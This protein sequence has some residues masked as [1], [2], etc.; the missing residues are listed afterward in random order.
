MPG[1]E[2]LPSICWFQSDKALKGSLTIVSSAT[3]TMYLLSVS[4][5]QV[6]GLFQG[7]PGTVSWCD[8]KLIKMTDATYSIS[9][10]IYR[11][12]LI[13]INIFPPPSPRLPMMRREPEVTHWDSP[14]PKARWWKVLEL[15]NAKLQCLQDAP[16]NASGGSRH[17]L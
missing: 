8:A 12:V 1:T 11:S 10:Q 13:A 17:K 7:F 3:L 6:S 14:P 16:W 15:E 4:G 2:R 5:T 9:L